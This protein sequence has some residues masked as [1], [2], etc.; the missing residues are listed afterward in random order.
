MYKFY[1]I[2]IVLLYH[3]SF[4]QDGIIFVNNADSSQI[5]STDTLVNIISEDV[6]N[7]TTNQPTSNKSTKK[8]LLDK[9]NAKGLKISGSLGAMF[10]YYYTSSAIKRMKPFT[11]QFTGDVTF[12]YKNV[13]EL[14]FSFVFSE[15]DRKFSQPFNQ[16]GVSPKYKWLTAHAGFRNINW[17]EHSMA[18]HNMLMVG[19][20]VNPSYFRAGLLFGRL[21]KVTLADS[22]KIDSLHLQT[23]V[24]TYKRLGAAVKIGA[25]TE[26]N[27]VDLIYF[28]AWDKSK[29]SFLYVNPDG[30]T[31][32]L[33]KSENAVFNIVTF[34]KIGKYITIKA[35]Y[36]LSTTNVDKSLVKDK[37]A[38]NADYPK[39]ARILMKPNAS[40]IGGHAASTDFEFSK[41]GLVTNAG[42]HLTTQ[43]FNTYGAYYL[44]TN[45]YD[46]YVKQV[47]PLQDKKASI[48]IQTK[49]T[50]D[51]LN[52]EKPYAT[53]RAI[54]QLAYDFNASKF[55]ISTQYINA[56]SKQKA[57][58]DSLKNSSFNDLLLNQMNHTFT[59]VPRYLIVKNEKSHLIMLNEVM[60]FLTDL[61]KNTKSNTAYF[62]NVVYLT[63]AFNLPV[64][65]FSMTTSVFS[66]YLKTSTSKIASYG[67]SFSSNVSIAKNKVTISDAVAY[68]YNKLAQVVNVDL[69][70]SYTPESHHKIYLSN[71]LIWNHTTNNSTQRFT[72]LRGNL[73]YLFTF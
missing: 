30:V 24:P 9:M 71:N 62:N 13:L 73:G 10:G 20:E 52:K 37:N 58:T 42:F 16:I 64:K 21:N 25:G 67:A 3:Y 72:E 49:F 69:T 68:T 14:P 5:I 54:S 19:A 36:A 34:N 56:Y 50:D 35:D 2:L 1:T 31:S 51:N 4:S 8:N 12:N 70:I 47:V 61:N 29:D 11:Y 23:F 39:I 15:Q 26:N 59:I 60:N 66:T 40:A 48:T 43:N 53:K 22:A 65:Y 28:R 7:A 32:F 18:G 63:Y 38:V 44:Q 33:P 41:D 55:G 6:T 57:I 45:F 17:S 46:V 27:Y